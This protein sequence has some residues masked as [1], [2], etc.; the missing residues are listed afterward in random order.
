MT[1]EE[2]IRARM[3]NGEPFTYGELWLPYGI[4]AFRIADREIQRWRK[5]GFI[6]FTREGRNVV[7]RLTD[8]GHA[9]S[10]KETA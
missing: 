9:A 7:W 10:F 8:A 2:K 1:V 6:S 3:G 5:K 4:E